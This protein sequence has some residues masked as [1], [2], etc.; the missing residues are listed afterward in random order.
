MGEVEEGGESWVLDDMLSF[1]ADKDHGSKKINWG[2][3]KGRRE[4]E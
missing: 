4:K 2:E 3:G 1:I